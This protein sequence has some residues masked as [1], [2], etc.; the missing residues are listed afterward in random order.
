MANE[1]DG[2]APLSKPSATPGPSDDPANEAP[3]AAVVML[4]IG[5][6]IG[7]G[8]KEFAEPLLD[9]SLKRTQ[10]WH[11]GRYAI[12]GLFG[13]M[14]WLFGIGK[15]RVVAEN[16]ECLAIAVVM[17]LILKHFLLEAY[18]IPT[19]SMQPTILGNDEAQIFDRVLVNKYAYLLDEPERFDVVVFKYP[20]DRSKNYIKRL[21]GLPG[22]RVSI[23]NGNVFVATRGEDGDYGAFSIARKPES[24]RDAV[25]KT[26]Y[27]SGAK[28]ESFEAVFDVLRGK[29][30]ADG[31]TIEVGAD[32]LVR[33]GHGDGIRDHYLD[34]YD[35]DWG[36]P[37]A[38]NATNAEGANNVAD[39]SLGFDVTPRAGCNEVRI[40]IAGQQLEHRAVLRVGG[41]ARLESGARGGND[42]GLVGQGGGSPV[43]ATL[44][45]STLAADR[46]SRVEFLH[47]DQELVLT[48]D[49]EVVLRHTYDTMP[50]AQ[51]AESGVE[52]EIV[53]GSAE[54][55][56][57][58]VRRDIH[59]TKVGKAATGVFDIP[60][61]GLLVL[62]DNTQNSSDGRFWKAQEVRFTDGTTTYRDVSN[63]QGIGPGEFV[64]IYGETY[65]LRQRT[66]ATFHQVDSDRFQ[67]AP[68]KLLLGKALAV[69]WP[70]VPHF[71]W[72]LIR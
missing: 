5:V 46:E 7:Y 34:G 33:F 31:D 26:L 57:L 22:E 15:G 20:L 56:D 54:I 50:S 28:G 52:F 13:W 68:R 58:R 29:A 63:P 65:R 32:S 36:I 18:K 72:K 11:Y 19:G 47:V 17:A 45:A 30:A 55:T 25:M 41:E 24:V 62:G 53:G 61:D 44:A 2:S 70:I 64:D 23:E 9:D 10:L 39:L 69:F 3:A 48:I 59:Y 12:V 71:R 38:S 14:G 60:D 21:I 8:I 43:V 51:A 6:L 66:D 37:M 1:R 27:P 40:V 42:D 16:I 49:G 35:P 67:F 4:V